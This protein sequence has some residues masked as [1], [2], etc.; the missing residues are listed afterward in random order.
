MGLGPLI[1]GLAFA[2]FA[3]GA[4]Y[5]AKPMG[6]AFAGFERIFLGWLAASLVAFLIPNNLHGFALL[7]VAVMLLAPMKPAERVCYYLATFPAL[8]VYH[9]THVPFPG[10]NYLIDLNHAKLA[11]IIV[12]APLFVM[13]F[14][15]AGERRGRAADW[16]I[17][18][19]YLLTSALTIRF[20]PVTSVVR[21]FI[22]GALLFLVPFFAISR[23]LRTAEEVDRA[24]RAVF[25]SALILCMLGLVS[26]WKS[27]NFY[28]ILLEHRSLAAFADT[29]GGYLRIS[30]TL[31][32]GLLGYMMAVGI[33][34]ALEL[35]RRRLI[36]L[37]R[38]AAYCVI[39]AAVCYLS[40]SR[41]AWLAA[42]ASVSTYLVFSRLGSSMRRLYLT[43]A[44]LAAIAIPIV[45][46]QIDFSRIDPYGSFDYRAELMT[47]GI[48]FI[49]NNPLFGAVNAAARPEF[50]HL[51]QG[52][53]I[54]DFVNTYL[55][56]G[57][58]Y[59]LT[60][61]LIFLA[62][63]LRLI[64]A[65]AGALDRNARGAP[66][67]ESRRGAGGV[68]MAAIFGILALIATV[69]AVSYVWPYIIAM[70]ALMRAYAQLAPALQPRSRAE[71]SASS[72]SSSSP[73]R[74]QQAPPPAGGW[75]PP[76]HLARFAPRE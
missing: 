15:R 25:V 45:V 34:I 40:G 23:N 60:G 53:G 16:L 63:I 24:I 6:P 12:L 61:L 8:P 33:I 41:G 57:V 7:A 73:A 29:R 20:L 22:D 70:L 3:I 64:A 11:A 67:Y 9:A 49:V 43:G 46:D 75:R 19:Y 48:R 36:G 26:A 17:I 42:F 76:K 4:A 31:M 54:V 66:D 58:H 39:F 72:S 56:I 62:A 30:S 37:I 2:C 5:L 14:F 71:P 18:G 47:T 38:M 44:A 13:S 27:W 1:A 28:T 69:S 59:G 21:E 74:D 35:R 68:L 51:V 55:Q 10:I 50:A 52:Q 65:G 32:T